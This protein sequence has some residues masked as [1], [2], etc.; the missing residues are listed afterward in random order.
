MKQLPRRS[1]T[2]PLLAG[3]LFVPILVEAGLQRAQIIRFLGVSVVRDLRDARQGAVGELVIGWEQRSDRHGIVV[4]FLQGAGSF[5]PDTELAI[6]GAIDR[7][8]RAAGLKTDSWNVS[9]A[10]REPAGVVYGDSVTGIVG[11]TV[12]AL[13]KGD[14]IPLDRT[15]TGTIMPDGAIG[16]VSSVPLK[17][18][19]AH[20]GRLRRVVVP[21]ALDATDADWF[22][23]FLMQISPI[24]SAAVAY[25]ALTDHSFFAADD[26][27]HH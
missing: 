27:V 3:L 25:Q 23:P 26:L 6:L 2:I 4:T 9:L 20:R 5:S 11:L 14:F 15:M 1:L 19:A 8:A 22:T 16:P 17:I 18:E 13:A 10:V 7:T 21:D 24:Q 12:V